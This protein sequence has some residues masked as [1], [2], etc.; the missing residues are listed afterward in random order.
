V[1]GDFFNQYIK[2]G[3]P[4]ILLELNCHP[5]DSQAMC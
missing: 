4:Y 2:A 3:T 1:S 5:N